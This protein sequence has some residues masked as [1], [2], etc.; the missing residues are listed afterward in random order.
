MSQVIQKLEVYESV[1]YYQTLDCKTTVIKATEQQ[2]NKLNNIVKRYEKNPVKVNL[3]LE[4]N[5]KPGVLMCD[6]G[7]IVIGI[8]PDGYSH[9]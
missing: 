2:I 9:S 1:S 8:E 5:N 6:F 7:F 4:N 3:L